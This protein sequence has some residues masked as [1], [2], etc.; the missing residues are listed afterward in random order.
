MQQFQNNDY[1]NILKKIRNLK[2]VFQYNTVV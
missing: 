1:H 2:K